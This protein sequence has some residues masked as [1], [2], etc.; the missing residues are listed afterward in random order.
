MTGLQG[1]KVAILAD[2]AEDAEVAHAQR[3]LNDAGAETIVLATNDESHAADYAALII[4]SAV[5]GVP[6]ARSVQLVREF[7][8]SDKP[9]V[10][11]GDGQRLLLEADAVAGRTLSAPAD[12]RDEIERCGGLVAEA[13]SYVDESLISVRAASELSRVIGRLVSS[14]GHRIDE[15]RLDQTS[16]QSFPASDPPQF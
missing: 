6:N 13:P 7:M 3:A 11:I 2:G 12:M 16:E 8:T 1:K 14:M 9:V 15:R 5:G 4:P 10:A